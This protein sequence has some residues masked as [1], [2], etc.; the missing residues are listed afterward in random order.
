MKSKCKTS[1]EFE[2]SFAAALSIKHENCRA[3]PATN[4]LDSKA[5]HIIVSYINKSK[6]DT[7]YLNKNKA[8]KTEIK[9]PWNYMSH[10]PDVRENQLHQM[11][12]DPKCRNVWP[13]LVNAY[14][15]RVTD[16][17]HIVL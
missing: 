1:K 16:T 6:T 2:P 11:S 8:F 10:S 7:L 14:W 3:N 4:T 9:Q 5:V 17:V 15:L 12:N 13:I